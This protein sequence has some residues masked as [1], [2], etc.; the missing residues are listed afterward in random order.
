VLRLRAFAHALFIELL[1]TPAVVFAQGPEV[2]LGDATVP[3][4]SVAKL[5]PYGVNIPVESYSSAA[6]ESRHRRR[7]N[8][9]GIGSSFLGTTSLTT[10]SEP[11]TRYKSPAQTYLPIGSVPSVTTIPSSYSE[12]MLY[13]PAL[14]SPFYARPAASDRMNQSYN[15]VEF[16]KI[17]P[18]DAFWAQPKSYGSDEPMVSGFRSLEP[19]QSEAH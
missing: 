9:G 8:E 10:E 4:E 7:G 11:L 17:E 6:F 19:I 3:P 5:E 13:S 14:S 16:S 2:R 1:L 15:L 12:K 18:Y